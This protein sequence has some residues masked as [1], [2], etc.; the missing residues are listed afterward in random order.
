MSNVSHTN[1]D[2]LT[3]VTEEK[4]LLSLKTND[5]VRDHIKKTSANRY[6]PHVI[7]GEIK[8]ELNKYIAQNK[9][10]KNITSESDIF[11][12]FTLFEFD[13]NLLGTFAVP[14]E[15]R[16][17]FVDLTHNLQKEYRSLTVSE[18]S[19][20]HLAALSYV[21]MLDSHQKTTNVL[22][23]GKTGD[24]DTRFIAAMG[25][26]VDRSTRQYLTAL[27]TLQTMKQPTLNV[28]IKTQ[29]AVVGQNQIVQ[30]NN[31]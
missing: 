12:A 26:E 25:K 21:R 11:K 29:T 4:D 22:A 10:L 30:A 28:N 7:L 31:K 2:N 14:E 27:Q 18:K 5:D 17:F 20:C 1:D 15:Y 9:R 13:N 23:R 24:M 16:T 8:V 3:K 6:A 19:F